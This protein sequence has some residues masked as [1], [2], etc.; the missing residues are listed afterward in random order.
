MKKFFVELCKTA[1]ACTGPAAVVYHVHLFKQYFDNG[2]TVRGGIY[3][4]PL[5]NHGIER[6]ITEAQDQTLSLS[7]AAAVV[8][9]VM[10]FA[11]IILRLRRKM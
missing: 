1:M 10:F 11:M 3:T 2:A 9:L 5:N 7:L 4:V 8:L 6:Y